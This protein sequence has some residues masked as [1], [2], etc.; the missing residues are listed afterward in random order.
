MKKFCSILL[1]EMM[2]KIPKGLILKNF[3][4]L[5]YYLVKETIMVRSEEVSAKLKF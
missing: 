1:L 2:T 5:F 4:F 3:S